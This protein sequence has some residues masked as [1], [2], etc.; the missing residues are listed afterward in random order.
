MKFL[1]GR[2]FFVKV[3]SKIVMKLFGCVGGLGSPW[4][5]LLPPRGAPGKQQGDNFSGKWRKPES[6]FWCVKHNKSPTKC[7]ACGRFLVRKSHESATDETSDFES[8][9]YA[10]GPDGRVLGQFSGNAPKKRNA[11]KKQTRD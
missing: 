2:R 1:G 9:G 6:D 7:G 3:L 11:M 5:P 10:A 8:G 4:V